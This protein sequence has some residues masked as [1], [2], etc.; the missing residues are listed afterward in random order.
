MTLKSN[1]TAGAASPSNSQRS[2]TP[3]GTSAAS[4]FEKL[5]QDNVDKLAVYN[6]LVKDHINRSFN[7]SILVSIAGFILIV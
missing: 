6:D 7:A 3:D 1:S 2:N 4:Y 5:V